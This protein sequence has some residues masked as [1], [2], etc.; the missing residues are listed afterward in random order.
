MQG[1]VFAGHY[2]NTVF[3]HNEGLFGVL[4]E[5]THTFQ[6]KPIAWMLCST[7]FLY[8]CIRYHQGDRLGPLG[9]AAY[10]ACLSLLY[11]ESKWLSGKSV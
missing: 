4:M 9:N 5:A 8:G 2:G 6:V 10:V 3:V 1:G 7:K 11:Q